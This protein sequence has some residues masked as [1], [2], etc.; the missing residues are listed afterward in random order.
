[1]RSVGAAAL[2]AICLVGLFSGP[3]HGSVIFTGTSGNL[4]ASATFTNLGG[5]MLEVL[6]E[7]TSTSDVLVP[8]DILT[9]VFF[10]LAG[11]PT[12][13]PV[14]ALLP[15]GST[16]FF[17]S[18]GGGNV[19]G[20]WAYVDGLS[21]APGGADEGIG[22]AGFGL[23]GGSNFGGPDLD[24]PAAVNGLNYGITSAGDNTATGNAP[25]TGSRPLIKSSVVYKLNGLG[26]AAGVEP[27]LT[28]VSFQYGTSLT[29]PNV[30]GDTPT[31]PEPT[32][33]IVWGALGLIV[34]AARFR[35]MAR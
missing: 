9:A 8:A 23:F 28:N 6:L 4:A 14:S 26:L 3:A 22:S 1:M 15:M 18:N 5:G 27:T 20:E 7:N 34:G 12:L 13:T 32:A 24:P 33:V 30:P 11:D 29:E 21:G 16:V 35:T 19:G 10:T 17:G 31:V 2:A 25:V